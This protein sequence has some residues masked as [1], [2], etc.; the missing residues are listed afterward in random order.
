MAIKKIVRL[1]CTCEKC[2]HKWT[3]R[4]DREPVQCPSCKSIRFNEPRKEKKTD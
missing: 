4:T 3:T 1:E 2:G